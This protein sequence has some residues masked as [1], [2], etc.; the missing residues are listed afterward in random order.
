MPARSPQGSHRRPRISSALAAVASIAVL[1]GDPG[2]VASASP[3][4]AVPAPAPSPRTGLAPSSSSA[5]A[6]RSG[7][8]ARASRAARPLRAAASARPARAR[9]ARAVAVGF[10]LAQ[11]GKP[12]RRG[13]T[14]PSAY[15]CS[16]LVG[17]GYAAAGVRLP[18]RAVDQYRRLPHVS[19]AAAR[20]GDLLFWGSDPRRPSSVSHVALY[21]GGG[22]ILTAPRTGSKVQI[23]PVYTKGL[24]PHAVRV[25]TR[26]KQ[27]LLPV[28]AKDSGD[29]VVA[30][31]RRL[32]AFG[33]RVPVDGRYTSATRDAVR[34][35]QR[36]S[37]RAATGE[38][39]AVSWSVLV[40]GGRRDRVD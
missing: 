10:G 40:R 30:V 6:L 5:P 34:A 19:R 35:V 2:A 29:R 15:D 21:L 38:V 11:L 28:T 3:A 13:G 8:G 32:R 16:G 20:P 33:Y 31:Q 26:D 23:K 18:R 24:M 4:P 14:G 1:M 17:A 22:M 12:Y 7:T 36:R 37:A 25:P 9:S 27:D 39:D